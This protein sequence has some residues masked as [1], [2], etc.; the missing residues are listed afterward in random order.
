[1][2]TYKTL[3]VWQKSVDL[4]EY[5]YVLTRNFPDDE[6]FNLTS[7]VRRSAVSIPS[8]IAEGHGRNTNGDFSRFLKIAFASSSELETQLLI[9]FRLK[10]ITQKEYDE[11]TDLLTYVRKMLSSLIKKTTDSKD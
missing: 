10:M 2:K 9:A 7:Q 4:V 3:I 5:V 1:M 8:N 11:V 6:K